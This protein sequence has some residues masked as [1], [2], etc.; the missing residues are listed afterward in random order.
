MKN[1]FFCFIFLTLMLLISCHKDNSVNAIKRIVNT[2]EFYINI[3]VFGDDIE[4][5]YDINPFDTLNIMGICEEPPYRTCFFDWSS[6]LF[7]T[8][9]LFNN[10]KI[11]I[12]ENQC[13]DGA[14]S[15]SWDSYRCS[16]YS[17]KTEENGVRVFTYGITQEDYENAEPIGG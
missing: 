8:E 15:I 1:H 2:T 17:S 3:K 13:L 14:A 12:F 6:S 16:G 5:T 7:G 10:Q 11:L 9:I 4:Y